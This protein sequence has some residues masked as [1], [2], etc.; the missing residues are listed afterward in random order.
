[1]DVHTVAFFGLAQGVG[2][3]SCLL[4]EEGGTACFSGPI[5]TLVWLPSSPDR[6]LQSVLGD[7]VLPHHLT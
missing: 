2:L 5:G 1:M 4:P 3:H 6:D 7:N